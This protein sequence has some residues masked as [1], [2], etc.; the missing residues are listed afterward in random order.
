MQAAGPQLNLDPAFFNGSTPLLAQTRL[1]AAGVAWG[2]DFTA[3][4]VVDWAHSE[5]LL[6]LMRRVFCIAS[7]A[8]SVRFRLTPPG[9]VGRRRENCNMGLAIGET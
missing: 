5:A 8:R 3:W 4:T 9:M 1:A 6:P 2:L 7:S